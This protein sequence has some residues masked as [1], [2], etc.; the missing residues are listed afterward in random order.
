MS[1]QQHQSLIKATSLIAIAYRCVPLV[2]Q[3]AG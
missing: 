2:E 1:I 3:T